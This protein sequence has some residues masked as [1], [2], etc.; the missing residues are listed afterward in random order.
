MASGRTTAKQ[1]PR[2]KRRRISDSSSHKCSLK[3]SVLPDVG[4]PKI[5]ES[6]NKIRYIW[7]NRE[8]R[9]VTF[10]PQSVSK[11]ARIMAYL[12]RYG[13]D[14]YEDYIDIKDPDADR[15]RFVVVE[16]TDEFVEIK[17]VYPKSEGYC[18][19]AVASVIHALVSE[20]NRLGVYY[21]SGKVYA[22]TANPCRAF[23]CYYRA[24]AANHYDFVR[25]E[26][27]G[28]SEATTVTDFMKLVN[29]DLNY[30]QSQEDMD[31]VSFDFT[32]Y[33]AST[34]QRLKSTFKDSTQLQL[35]Y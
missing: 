12:K 28:S 21:T 9:V 8:V 11:D 33:F 27:K 25:A 6:G 20:S 18:T 17:Y 4:T 1:P 31:E 7:H 16:G 26:Y 10:V 14:E 15:D 34:D 22:L 2:L 30:L 35:R 5:V 29:D 32:M 13:D 19:L 23:N 3:T 24:F